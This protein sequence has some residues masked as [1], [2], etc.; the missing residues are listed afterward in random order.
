MILWFR[1]KFKVY[2]NQRCWCIKMT[3]LILQLTLVLATMQKSVKLDLQEMLL[4]CRK[5]MV[6]MFCWHLI[7]RYIMHI[8]LCS[9]L[10]ALNS[11]S[12][13]RHDRNEGGQERQPEE[14]LPVSSRKVHNHA[15]AVFC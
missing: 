3:A 7:F 12:A 14:E 9:H 6:C 15:S 13:T 8:F 1:M 11:S 10:S 2:E 5:I 4:N